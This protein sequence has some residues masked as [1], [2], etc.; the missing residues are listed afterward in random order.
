MASVQK[1]E[2]LPHT[3]DLRVRVFGGSLEELFHNALE[4]LMAIMGEGAYKTGPAESQQI[5]LT[6]DSATNL[7]IEFLNEV[8]YLSNVNKAVYDRVEF[9]TFSG[10]ELAGSLHGHSID[11]FAED[12]KA[13]TYHGAEIRRGGADNFV[14]ELVF[15]V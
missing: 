1:F 3:A 14:V 4:A 5:H 12:V 9:S 15:D 6:A 2:M 13:V 8:L 7:L 11:G 10:K